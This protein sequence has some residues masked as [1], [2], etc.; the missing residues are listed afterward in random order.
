MPGILIRGGTIINEGKSWVGDIAIRDKYLVPIASLM[1]PERVIDARGFWVLPGVID[2][3]VHFREPGLETKGTIAS[4]SLA[5]LA[6]GITSFMEMPNTIPPATTQEL[7]QQKFRIAQKEA[8]C[9]YSFYLGATNHNLEEIRALD[10]RKVCGVKVFMGSSTGD[11]LVDS[12]EALHQ[13]FAAA[14]VPVAV[15]SEDE[16]TIKRNIAY[17]REFYGNRADARI[18]PQVRSEE[19]CVKCTARAIAYCRNTGGH[20]H[21]LHISTARE[22]DMIRQAK[23]EGLRV[24]AE[25][26]VHHLWFSEEN[27]DVLG[28][29]IKWNPSIKTKNDRHKLREGLLDGTIDIVAT[30]HAPHELEKKMQEYFDAPSGGPLV[31]FSLVMMLEMARQ[32]CWTAADVVTWM[33]HKPADLFRVDRRG[34]LREGYYADVVLVDPDSLWIIR[35]NDSL[36]KVKWTPLEGT[37]VHHRIVAAIVNGKVAYE[38]GAPVEDAKSP[39]ELRFLR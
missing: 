4:E 12:D 31:Q 3:Q 21:L 14:Q 26:C 1:D 2:D 29:L 32:H 15:H 35:G 38:N 10:P 18:H 37:E 5:A 34:Y 27:Y 16:E 8:W 6:G 23:E 20:L 28:N 17:Y 13:L 39:M 25:V 22:V 24:T 19:A 36:S 9:N 33:S 7:L 30:D 11:L